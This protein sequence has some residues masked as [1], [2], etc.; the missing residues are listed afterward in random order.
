VPPATVELIGRLSPLYVP[1]SNYCIQ[2]YV[3]YVAKPPR[4]QPNPHEVAAVREVA[5]SALLAP[6]N[7]GVERRDE[8]GFA[9]GRRVPYM[10]LNGWRVWGA[11]AMILNELALVLAQTPS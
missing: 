2:P 6:D 5:L 3:G 4:L 11:T 10:A 7:R 9:R 1:V 8:P